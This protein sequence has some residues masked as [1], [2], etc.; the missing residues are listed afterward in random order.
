MCRHESLYEE[1]F[2]VKF[3]NHLRLLAVDL[4]NEKALR[5]P[6]RHARDFKFNFAPAANKFERRVFFER[7]PLAHGKD[8]AEIS[9]SDKD[10]TRL[11]SAF[12]LR[13]EVLNGDS[14]ET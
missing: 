6:S 7:L 13:K 4:L 9:F 5:S 14:S 1:T 3:K 11:S 10:T 8:K 2:D 12:I